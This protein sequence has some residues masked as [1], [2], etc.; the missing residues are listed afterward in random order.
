MDPEQIGTDLI[1]D[2]CHRAALSPQSMF[3][4]EEAVRARYEERGCGQSSTQTAGGV[5]QGGTSCVCV[6]TGA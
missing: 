4:R 1:L 5:F 2:Q 3:D 6:K